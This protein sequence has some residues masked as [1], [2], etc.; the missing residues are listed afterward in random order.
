MRTGR[1]ERQS[2]LHNA[3]KTDG[4]G[5]LEIGAFRS[6]SLRSRDELAEICRRMG[7][8]LTCLDKPLAIG[9][10]AKPGFEPVAVIAAEYVSDHDRFPR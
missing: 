10:R 8:C 9:L 2:V 5:N 7:I 6:R 4:A 3:T 1:E